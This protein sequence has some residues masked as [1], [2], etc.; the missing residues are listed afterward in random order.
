MR[1]HV[2]WEMVETLFRDSVTRNL[3]HWISPSSPHFKLTREFALSRL[4][5]GRQ[6]A[7]FFRPRFSGQSIRVLDLGAGNGGVSVGLGNH[8]DFHITALDIIVNE[9]L[10]AL[11]TSTRLPLHQVAGSGH[12]LPFADGSFDLVLCL[13]TIEHLSNP[14]ALGNQIMR[15]LRPGGVCM[16]TT[17]ARFRHLVAP[18]PH[19]GVRGL[20]LLPDPFQR[21]LM[22]RVLRRGERYDVEHIFWTRRGIT[23]HFPGKHR[24][25]TLINI[26]WP[27]TPRTPAHILWY[28]ARGWL[29]DRIIVHKR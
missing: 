18:D 22:T 4:G 28:L 10:R 1:L 14:S 11:R 17:P 21:A 2:S 27:G 5:E 15:V 7:A 12:Q 23:R 16:I 29:W 19:Y 26:P 3:D 25:E 20:L 9:D 6:L 24:V 13:E 8:S